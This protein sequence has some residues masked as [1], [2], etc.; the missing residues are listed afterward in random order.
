MT[1]KT[2]KQETLRD[3][4]LPQFVTYLSFKELQLAQVTEARLTIFLPH[5]SVNML[6]IFIWYNACFEFWT[7]IRS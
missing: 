4:Y 7:L 6:M 3:P 1:D 2:N 5:N